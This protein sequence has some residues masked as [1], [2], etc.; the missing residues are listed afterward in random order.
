MTTTIT[1][2]REETFGEP[3]S[4]DNATNIAIIAVSEA[5]SARESTSSAPL[6][7]S[8]DTLETK[9]YQTRMAI[10]LP[11]AFLTMFTLAFVAGSRVS[12]QL[13][14]AA[15]ELEESSFAQISLEE[16]T[17]A[18]HRVPSTVL[19]EGNPFALTGSAEHM[20]P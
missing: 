16:G 2:E 17:E 18:P 1:R 20:T 13:E 12:G 19:I 8:N 3:T 6:Y 4:S 7:T 11:T 9:A 15:S 10:L 5:S 14:D